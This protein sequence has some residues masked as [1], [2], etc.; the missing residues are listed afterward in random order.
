MFAL[1]W[2]IGHSNSV[3]NI[4]E[5]FI[6]ANENKLCHFHIHD[7]VGSQNHLVLGSGEINLAQRLSIAKKHNCQCVV[8]TKTVQ[9]LRQSVLWLNE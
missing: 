1:T 3:K 6:M 9:S 7:S 4:D 5:E 2:D 8:E